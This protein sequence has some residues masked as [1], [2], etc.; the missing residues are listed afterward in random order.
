MSALWLTH[1]DPP[2]LPGDTDQP[3]QRHRPGRIAAVEGQ[4]AGAL[5]AA[6]QQPVLPGLAA[7]RSLAVVQAE[8]RPVVPAVALD[9]ATGGDALPRPRRDTLEQGVGAVGA[10]AGDLAMIAG[11]RQDVADPRRSSPARSPGQA[12]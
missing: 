9:A 10:P 4:L 12:P 11:H 8:E 1:L 2:A 6:D 3:G 7:G 5:V